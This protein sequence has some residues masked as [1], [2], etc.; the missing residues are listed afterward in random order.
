MPEFIDGQ[1]A[2]IAILAMWLPIGA[3]FLRS[4]FSIST[5]EIFSATERLIV[6]IVLGFLGACTFFVLAGA[7]I[8]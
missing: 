7:A 8:N 6:S 5:P 2:A 3:A 4:R 1:V